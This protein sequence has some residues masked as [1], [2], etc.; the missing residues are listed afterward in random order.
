VSTY[1]FVVEPLGKQ[2]R[3]AFSCGVEALDRY[4][5]TQVTQ[6]MR[7]QFAA[8]YV[9]IDVATG[10]CAGYYTLSAADVLVTDLSSEMA[11]KLPRYPAV[12]VARLGRL[13]IHRAF[14]GR[15]LGSAL[16]FNAA[17]R[18]A[19]SEV[20]VFALIVDAKDENAAAFYRHHGFQSFGSVPRQLVAPIATFKQVIR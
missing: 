7:R 6:D 8:C 4:F 13:A 15:K 16:L 1:P 10:V 19:R 5:H 3:S 17:L 18:A 9:A 20:A 14:Q 11:R 2:D 12:P